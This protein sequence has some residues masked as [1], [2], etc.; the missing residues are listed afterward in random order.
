MNPKKKSA[1]SKIF[2]VSGAILLWAPILFMFLTAIISSIARKT[3]L[4]DFL[5]LAELFPVIVLG[6][7]LLVLASLL[8]RIFRK[9]FIWGSIVALVSLVFG[10]ILAVSSGLASGDIPASG[11]IFITVNGTMILFNII[12]IALAILAIV[13]LRRIYRKKPEQPPEN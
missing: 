9:W 3:V 11:G 2:A 10:Q 6:L 12:V 13:L 1:L 4:F 8:S 5:I 7:V